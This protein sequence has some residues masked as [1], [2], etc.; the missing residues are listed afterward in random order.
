MVVLLAMLAFSIDTGYMFTMQSQLDRSVDAAA[1]AGASCLVEG[2]DTAQEAVLEYLVR[3]PVGRPGTIVTSDELVQ[4]TAEFLA[5]HQDDYEILYGN[6]NPTTEQFE[7]TSE[8]PSAVSVALRYPNLPLF[9]GRALGKDSFDVQSRAIAMYQPRDIMVVLDFSGSMNDDSELQA[10]SKF[11]STAVMNGLQQIYEELGSPVYGNLPFT[12]QWATV[13][14]VDPVDATQPKI[15]VQYRFTSVYVTST[16]TLS[17][18][19]LR[20]SNGN[21]QTFLSSATSGT[22][23]GSGTNAGRQVTEVYVKTVGHALPNGE[24]FNFTSSAITNTLKKALGLDSIA[25]PYPSGSWS[26]YV[27]HA[28]SSGTA[29]NTAGFR[30]K[31]GYANLVNYWLEQKPM[32]SQTPDLW[33]VSAQPVTAVKDAVDLFMEFITT[34]DTN[35]R[36]GLVVYN[37]SS[38]NARLETGLTTDL[39]LVASIARQRQAGHYHTYTN[40]G[41]G[42]QTAREHLQANGRTNAFKMI[43]LMTDGIANYYNGKYDVTAAYNH[44]LAEANASKTLRYPV[45]AI[46]LGAGADT[47]LMQ[48]V[49]DITESRHF[50]VPGGQSVADYRDGLIEVFEDI[51]NTRPLKLVK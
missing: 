7:E 23:Q 50:N 51:A 14:G 43:V 31:F 46:S 10:I 24:F 15:T 42:M 25:Y 45:V 36:L 2:T 33:K 9:F 22:F 16:K 27:D 18:V 17:S 12:P 34:V 11:G 28:R 19:K 47:E 5:A 29:N 3:N 32:Y 44:V 30:F 39:P 13:Q 37:S 8:L 40:I 6:W 21:Y 1:L 26:T 35:D 38:G 49:A 4:K 41:A 20:F 48:S